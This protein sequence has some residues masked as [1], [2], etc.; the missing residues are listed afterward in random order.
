[1]FKFAVNNNKLKLRLIIMD[2]FF[3]LN[4]SQEISV[5]VKFNGSIFLYKQSPD[6]LIAAKQIQLIEKLILNGLKLEMDDI[7]SDLMIL[8]K[9]QKLRIAF[10]LAM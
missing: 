6:T 7:K 5:P 1:V 9:K 4:I 3:V 10:Y 2:T 8:I